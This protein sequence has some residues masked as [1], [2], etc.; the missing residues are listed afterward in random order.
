LRQLGQ[1]FLPHQKLLQSGLGITV[2]RLLDDFGQAPPFRHQSLADDGLQCV[3]TRSN[4]PLLPQERDPFRE[5]EAR[6]DV[7][8]DQLGGSRLESRQEFT[9]PAAVT[10]QP[11]DFLALYVVLFLADRLEAENLAREVAAHQKPNI[12]SG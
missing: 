3:V 8:H 10:E 2:Q 6:R 4:H 1:G 9:R 7:A 12:F 5:D 11:K